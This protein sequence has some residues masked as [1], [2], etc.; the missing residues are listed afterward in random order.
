MLSAMDIKNKEFKKGFR[1]YNEEEVDAFLEKVVKDYEAL[2]RENL[3]LKETVER[4]SGKID[5]YQNLESTLQSTLLIAQETASEVRLNAKKE[6]DLKMQDTENKTQ[7]MIE[8]STYK[9]QRMIEETENKVRQMLNEADEK[10]KK[11]YEEL[12][13]L[14]KETQIFKA[15]LKSMLSSQLQ[16]LENIEQDT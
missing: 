8:D 14:K 6:V 12:E 2:Y 4:V 3:E 1:G 11:A 9:S 5:Y 15:K 13:N 10:V 16:I 7:K